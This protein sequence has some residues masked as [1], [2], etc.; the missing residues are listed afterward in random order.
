[1]AARRHHGLAAPSQTPLVTPRPLIPHFPTTDHPSRSREIVNTIPQTMH[2]NMQL[3]SIPLAHSPQTT[4]WPMCPA[5]PSLLPWR[6]TSSHP[7]DCAQSEG[8]CCGS[9]S[10]PGHGQ[11][12]RIEDHTAHT[13][14]AQCASAPTW[15]LVNSDTVHTL[16]SIHFYNPLSTFVCRVVDP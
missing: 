4:P 6:S 7:M 11:V 13:A 15:C 8:E 2:I 3:S 9:G 5:T 12:H 10:R 16:I 14:S 1:M